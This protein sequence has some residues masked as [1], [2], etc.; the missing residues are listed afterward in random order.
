MFFEC[1]SHQHQTVTH[2]FLENFRGKNDFLV[3][4][5]G[6]IDADLFGI[7]IKKPDKFTLHGSQAKCELFL[8]GPRSRFPFF[9][10]RFPQ[11]LII[12]LCF[13]T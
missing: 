12:A 8:Y 11:V 13:A 7:E 2:T 9:Q 1:D 5:K 10:V 3:S 6:C 4:L